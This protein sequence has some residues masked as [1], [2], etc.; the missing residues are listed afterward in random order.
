MDD[1]SAVPV[2]AGT[3]LPI[4]DVQR[5]TTC[6]AFG[7]ESITALSDVSLRIEKGEFICL[8]G[9]SGCGKSTLLRMVGGFEVPNQARC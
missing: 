6:F 2:R 8:I 7:A 5:V 9:P 1:L 3:M 4:L